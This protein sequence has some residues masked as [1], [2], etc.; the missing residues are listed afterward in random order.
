[1]ITDPRTT[2]DARVARIL[3]AVAVA[4][5]AHWLAFAEQMRP[6]LYVALVATSL[7]VPILDLIFPAGRFV[8]H[9]PLEANR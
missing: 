8:W 6:A 5:L 1:M 9:R 4:A 3:F 7:L 2:P